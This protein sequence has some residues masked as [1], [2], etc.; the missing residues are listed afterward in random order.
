[1]QQPVEGF[2]LRAVNAEDGALWQK[3]ADAIRRGQYPTVTNQRQ[4]YRFNLRYQGSSILQFTWADYRG[5]ALREAQ[6]S[7]QAK[8]LIDDLKSADGMMLF[9]DMKALAAGDD[10]SNQIGRM[11]VLVTQALKELE[12]PIAIA[13]VLTKTDLVTDFQPILLDRLQGL[14]A[15]VNASSTISGAMIPI[16]C[17]HELR[18]VVMPLLFALHMTVK[19]QAESARTAA[20]TQEAL[21]RSYEDKSRGV[22]GAINWISSKLDEELT[23][24]QKANQARSQATEKLQEFNRIRDPAESLSYYVQKLPLI[25]SHLE[26]RDYVQL[27]MQTRRGI[28]TQTL[29]VQDPFSMFDD[30]F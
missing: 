11:T 26:V 28:L 7:D 17:G 8:A 1:M 16:A 4:E 21:A 22:T 19:W 14:I 23:P 15:A 29:K 6:T 18:N 5:G 24:R 30:S 3:L 9:C 13:I 25:Q 10:R 12:R 20:D 2:S 27:L